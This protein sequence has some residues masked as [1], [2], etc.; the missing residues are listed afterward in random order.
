MLRKNTNDEQILKIMGLEGLVTILRTLIAVGGS[1]FLPK[2]STDHSNNGKNPNKPSQIPDE[3]LH[4]VDNDEESNDSRP[5]SRTFSTS[6]NEETNGGS[7]G[8]NGND[9]Q[10]IMQSYDRKQKNQEEIETGIL[11]FNLSPK[12][13]IAYLSS[14]GH[15]EHT[16]QG[17][18]K[19]FHQYCEKLDKTVIG[20]YLGRE[21]EYEGGFC[22]KVLHEYVDMFDFENMLF[23][24]SIRVLLS[25]FRLPGE[26]QKIDRIMEKF[27]ERYYLQNRAVFASADMA[28]ILAFSTIMLQ[29]NL[30]NPAIRD[31]KRMTKEQF[32][33][34]NTGISADGE[35]PVSLLSEI[36]D[37]IAAC[38]ISLNQDDKLLKLKKN[39]ENLNNLNSFLL[40]PLSQTT[41]KKRMDAYND[42]RKEMIR[43]SE[44]IFKQRRRN[45]SNLNNIVT[46][47]GAAGATGGGGGGPATGT[48]AGTG[49]HR[50]LLFL[51]SQGDVA[52]IPPMFEVA[53]APM[54]SVFSQ[55]LEMND[56]DEVTS[57][58]LEGFQL[59]IRL[60][61]RCDVTTA[62][63][64]Y[65]TTLTKFTT[66][67]MIKEMKI[68]H[69]DGIKLL[70]N[71]A[72]T[73]GDFLYETWGQILRCISHLSRL[74]L[75]GNG[76]HSD[77]MFFSETSSI[78]PDKYSLTS[79][80]RGSS[81]S[82]LNFGTQL[83]TQHH[84]HHPLDPFKL[85]TTPTKAETSRLIEET[86]AE[87]LLKEIDPVLLDRI[88]LN[89]QNL[90]SDSVLYFVNNLCQVSLEEISSSS[91]SSSLYYGSG[92]GGGGGGDVMAS[93]RIFSLQKLVEVADFNMHSRPR[94]AWTQLWSVLAMHFTT[95]GVHENL[96]LSMYAIDSLKQLSIKFL[97][98]AELSN[99]N[100]QRL[101][102][103]PFE[104][105]MNRSHSSEIKELILRCL[106]IMVLACASNIRSGWRSIFAV[107]SSAATNEKHEIAGIAFEITER[108][109]TKQFDLLIHDFVDLMN[110]FVAFA[111]GPHLLISLSALSYLSH[112]ADHLVEGKVVSAL[113]TQYGQFESKNSLGGDSSKSN[114]IGEDAAVFRLWWPLLLGLSTRVADSRLQIR[115]RAVE[116]LHRVL[117]T[118][119]NMFSPQTWEVIF[120]G[121]LFPMIDSAKID[122]TPQ[123]HSQ[124]PTQNPAIP[125]DPASWI[126]TTA[127][128]ALSVCVS[129]FIQ[130]YEQGLTSALLPELITMFT[131]CINQEIESLSRLSLGL[132]VE[133]LL[134][135]PVNHQTN[136]LPAEVASIIATK[137]SQIGLTTLKFDFGIAGTLS[138]D[139]KTAPVVKHM[140]KNTYHSVGH[141]GVTENGSKRFPLVQTPYGIGKVVDEDGVCMKSIILSWGAMLYSC[142]HFIVLNRNHD[143]ASSSSSSSA[144]KLSKEQEWSKLSSQNMSSMVLAL[145][146][147]RGMGDIIHTH[148]DSW[149][150]EDL[151][152]LLGT[153]QCF[154]DHSRCF[155]SDLKLR[156][157]LRSKKF[158][159]F[160]DN[161]SRLP[162]LLEQETRSAAQIF[163]FGYRL[164]SEEKMNT[165]GNAR[166]YLV[167]PILKRFPHF[168]FFFFFDQSHSSFFCSVI[169]NLFDRYVALDESSLT[170][171]DSFI[172]EE[173]V[174]YAPPLMIGVKGLADIQKEQFY[175]NIEWISVVMSRLNLCNDRAIRECVK[176]VT[177]NQINPL[178]ISFCQSQRRSSS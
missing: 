138:F 155:N 12:K 115:T 137:L 81:S 84:H 85:F 15:I 164:Y 159:K 23:D 130:Y 20:D 107:F 27:A 168:P 101:F 105:I 57:L 54:L 76:L 158:M 153:L 91:S 98:K 61:C 157:H 109:M 18:A 10:A 93:P 163:L 46:A 87:L 50:K 35:L 111:S 39:N 60:A 96:A 52:F 83:T 11:K 175:R 170:S 128:T 28:F 165:T 99:F 36:Y 79:S 45:K 147:I 177:D 74:Q 9:G 120:K 68:K 143:P 174:V 113:D 2:A 24:E 66:L 16:P 3:S 64:T 154:Y 144:P 22:V 7:C 156:T 141:R 78:S 103:K 152:L 40:F 172:P 59:S 5:Y 146:F 124:W 149:S 135:I 151:T 162:H 100:F 148:Y 58:C 140:F 55:M 21:V 17:I 173:L 90:S 94:L 125:R 65:L 139:E 92:G 169:L 95:V 176:L 72:L 44:A 70:I 171:S 13:G 49:G 129:L 19:F 34:Q 118:Y 127:S 53:W 121:V 4:S 166:A 77:E 110:C 25:G 122:D 42:E 161:P 88:F 51:R 33:K 123:P 14:L 30:H 73:E 119:G 48:N 86:N 82:G 1:L 37:R 26:A 102:L 117:K 71:I 6:M 31:D 134:Q 150:L 62:R 133:L 126:S 145:E 114:Q 32:I 116:T 43:A 132:L 47:T 63:D 112:C 80:R 97:Q 8:G 38:P 67:E 178:L 104:V 69:I 108:L 41:D 89:S 167:E 136:T 131:G 29:T 75:F 160:R 106:D 142:D 56:E